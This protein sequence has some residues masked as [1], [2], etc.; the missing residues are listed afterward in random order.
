[1]ASGRRGAGRSPSDR[2]RRSTGRAAVL[3]PRSG[4]A[5]LHR[6]SAS[7][8]RDPSSTLTGDSTVG[9]VIAAFV[10]TRVPAADRRDVRSALS[11]IDAELGT[12]PIR[13]VSARNVVALLGDLRAA[14]LSP[15]RE[16][17][18]ADALHALF[19]FAVARRL[20]AASP[21]VETTRP[22]RSAR[23][24]SRPRPAPAAAAPPLE[25]AEELRTPTLSMLALGARVAW[26]T[27]LIVTTGF[28]ALLLLL[29]LELA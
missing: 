17:Q 10:D 7:P 3:P 9:A 1:M 28:A 24:R 2:G 4:R 5:T 23:P 19:A 20:I 8:D 26:W 29:V 21:I 15:R 13:T 16:T 27:A 25:Q 6:M 18:V 12:R 11:H 14:G 22:E